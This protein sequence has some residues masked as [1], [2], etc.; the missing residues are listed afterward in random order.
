VLFMIVE[1]FKDA[2]P[3]PVYRHLRD[4]GR[5]LPDGLHYVDSWVEPNFG[6]CFQV[7]E[8]DDASLIQQWVLHWGDLAAIE[9]IPVVTSAETRAVVEPLL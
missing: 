8:T 7:M 9:V 4:K 6:R 5:G 1:R 2:D 3:L